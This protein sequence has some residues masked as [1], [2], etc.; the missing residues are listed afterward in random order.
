MSIDKKFMEMQEAYEEKIK[1]LEAKI[2]LYKQSNKVLN[3]QL[4]KST[5]HISELNDKLAESEKERKHLKDW[6][7]NEILTSIDHESYY[8]TINEYEEEVKKLKQQLAEKDEELKNLA[9]A[10]FESATNK[11]VL[12]TTQIIN[13]DK[14]KFAIGQLEKVKELAEKDFNLDK[15]NLSLARILDKIDNQIEEL[16]KEMK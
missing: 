16:K 10:H 4:N 2:E 1:V 7:D 13:Q 12:T 14:I 3:D 11:P 15:G 8:A 6:L 9:L 5:D